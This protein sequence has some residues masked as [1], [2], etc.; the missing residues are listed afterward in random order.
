MEQPNRSPSTCVARRELLY[1]AP[2]GDVED[3]A[4]TTVG[5]GA[6]ISASLP[7]PLKATE[8]PKRSPVAGSVPINFCCVHVACRNDPTLPPLRVKT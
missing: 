7:S 2:A 6:P 3:G 1:Q 5:P 4:A 8:L